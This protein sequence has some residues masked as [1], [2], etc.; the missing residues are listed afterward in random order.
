MQNKQLDYPSG[1]LLPTKHQND[2]FT[3]RKTENDQII[4]ALKQTNSASTENILRAPIA[5]REK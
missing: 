5:P 1:I 3:M 4:Y 2:I